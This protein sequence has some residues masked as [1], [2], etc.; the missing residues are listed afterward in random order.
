MGVDACACACA[1][2][3]AGACAMEDM[4]CWYGLGG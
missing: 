3:G 2:A 4:R 1:G